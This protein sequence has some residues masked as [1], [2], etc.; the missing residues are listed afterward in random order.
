MHEVSIV[1][2]ILKTVIDT[3][4][5]AGASRVVSVKLRIGDMREVVRESLDFA[6]EAFRD[7]DPLTVDCTLDVENIS[8]RSACVQCGHEFEHDRFHC[9]CP[10]CGSG[11]TITLA[12]KELEI[13]SME[14]ETP[15]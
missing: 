1:D 10:Q 6:W 11:Q 3:A 13:V 9:R 5:G 2:G 8:P 14:I 4:R 12:G 7:D 15:D